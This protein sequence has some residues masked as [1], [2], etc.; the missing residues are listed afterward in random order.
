[1]IQASPCPVSDHSILKITSAKKNKY[2]NAERGEDGAPS[3]LA[4]LPNSPALARGF[5]SLAIQHT[6]GAPR[7]CTHLLTKFLNVT[8]RGIEPRLPG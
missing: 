5:R 1:M 6:F 2:G 3:P 4:R 8:P 7:F